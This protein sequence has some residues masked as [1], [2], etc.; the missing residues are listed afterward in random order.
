[1]HPL[2]LRNAHL[3]DPASGLDSVCD[4]L[5]VDGRVRAVG[6][7]AVGGALPDGARVVD[8]TGLWL[9]P[10]LVDA[11]VH[12]REPGFTHKETIRTGSEAAA[13]GGYTSVVCEPNTD[14]A[15]DSVERVRALAEKAAGE[16]R[17]QVYFK[18]A[19]TVGRKGTE[20]TRIADLAREP[21]VVAL[22]D[23]GDPL[24]DPSVMEAV[25]RAATEAAIVVSPH[26]EDSP[27]ALRAY[28]AGV[29]PGFRP[30]AAF[31]N[32][33][34]YVRRDLAIAER[35]GCRI[36][37]SHVSRADV[38]ALI[39]EA[40]ASGAFDGRV[41]LEAAPHHL[42]LCAEEFAEGDVPAVNPPIRSASDRD[43]LANALLDG[44][45]DAVASDHAPH[46][47]DD[48]AAGANGL[49]GLETTLGLMLTE[50]VGRRGWSR[51]AAVEAMSLHPARIFGLPAGTLSKGTP[52]D[53]VLIDPSRKWTVDPDCF[54]SRSRNT[55][56]AG[57]RL[58]GKAVATFVAGRPVYADPE[59]AAVAALSDSGERP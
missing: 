39:A 5:V 54:R 33:A 48:K 55:P 23:D 31:E 4:V 53:M 7:H 17:V 28:E 37:F 49:I 13:A 50:F 40:R 14:P 43:A 11:H 42:L 47:A 1:M 35:T 27:S 15:T 56:Y 32:E 2:L 16:A 45:I 25:C 36:H 18:A 41:S 29:D 24:V 8:C 44:R 58:E 21:A 20:L 51:G 57:M 46:T 52:A 30:A 6:E 26:E 9:W 34:N 22:S 38:L 10:G 19:M 12:F 59:C 3:T